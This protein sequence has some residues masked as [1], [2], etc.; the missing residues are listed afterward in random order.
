MTK[1]H[2]G[3]CIL[4]SAL[5]TPSRF[6]NI[7][8]TCYLQSRH[9]LLIQISSLTAPDRNPENINIEGHSPH[10]MDITWEVTLLL[11]YYRYNAI[12]K[13]NILYKIFTSNYKSIY[14]IFSK[15]CGCLTMNPICGPSPNLCVY[16]VYSVI[17][18]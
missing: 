17:G 8:C 9:I 4:E 18:V 5:N 6:N 1:G 11:T 13:M 15:L 7:I 14:T 10:Q 3:P 12:G 16:C 2:E